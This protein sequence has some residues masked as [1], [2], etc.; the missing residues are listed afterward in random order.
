MS[1]AEAR[2]PRRNPWTTLGSR[3][4]YENPWIAVREDRVLRPDGQPGIYGVVHFRHLA[5]GVVA[6][7]ADG[8]AVL[9]GQHRYPLGEYS[10]EIPEGGGEMDATPLEG[11]RRELREETGLTAATWTYLGAA[12]LSNSATD[13]VGY[14]FLAE[15]LTEGDAEPE[16]TEELRVRRV[17][18]AR[19]VEMALT[20]EITD[21]LSVIGLLRAEH[22]LR[23]GRSWRPRR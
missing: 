2:D 23:S 13:E 7:H 3:P 12:H 18:F 1:D 15:D 11:A 10:W 8:D 20:G 14:L 21:A 17:P 22:Y 5:I 9:V 4:I 6:L 19:A 16:G